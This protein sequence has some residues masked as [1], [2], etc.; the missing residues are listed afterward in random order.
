MKW[1]LV[2]CAAVILLGVLNPGNLFWDSAAYIGMGKWLYS[3]GASGLWE[4]SRPVALPLL[5]GALWKLGVSPFGMQIFSL[6]VAVGFLALVY[7]TAREVMDERRAVFAAFLVGATATFLVFSTQPMTEILSTALLLGGILLAIKKHPFL[8]GTLAGLAFMTRFLQLI[9]A[10]ILGLWL[11]K[12]KRWNPAAFF[13][14]GFLAPVMPYLIF[15]LVLYGQPF[16]PFLQQWQLTSQTGWLW[17][18]PWFWYAPALLFENIALLLFLPGLLKKR[19]RLFAL[20]GLLSLLVYSAIPQKEP[21]FFLA[22][23][24][25]LAIVSAAAAPRNRVWIIAIIVL[26]TLLVFPLVPHALPP[27]PIEM[28]EEAALVSSPL[29]AVHSS[30]KAVPAYY[31]LFNAERARELR[32]KIGKE[33]MLISDCD[34]PCRPGDAA[35]EEEKGKLFS[36][37]KTSSQMIEKDGCSYFISLRNPPS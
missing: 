36:S 17:H 24:P 4:P 30:A 10:V 13:A 26:Q 2:L 27:P 12:G 20:L 15:N 14:L 8:A 33:R 29:Y 25:Y 28:G 37:L 19:V 21:R 5:L 6:L 31:P 35:C 32:G 1:L 22:F 23:L 7:F 11:W 9:P 18:E 3:D 16:F 34:L